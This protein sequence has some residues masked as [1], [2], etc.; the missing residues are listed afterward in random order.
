MVRGSAAKFA[1]PLIHANLIFALCRVRQ[2]LKSVDDDLKIST[3]TDEIF[4]SE[5]ST[6]E[7]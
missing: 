5:R 4:R 3:Q 2:P 1:N 6:V 7:N